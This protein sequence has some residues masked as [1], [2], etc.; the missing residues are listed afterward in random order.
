M[1]RVV[2]LTADQTRH[3]YFANSVNQFANVVGVFY[4][5]IKYNPAKAARGVSI[6]EASDVAKRHFAL[7]DKTE[8]SYFGHNA[9]FIPAGATQAQKISFKDLNSQALADKICSLQPDVILTFGVSVLKEP[10]ISVLP[11]RI[12][13][14]HIGLSPYYKGP[15]GPFF[16]LL[17]GEP[18]YCGV[19]IH[20]IDAGV[21]DGNIVHQGIPY[22]IEEDHPHT[23]G[24]KCMEIGIHLLAQTLKEIEC[25]ALQTVPQ[26]KEGAHEYRREDFHYGQ[27]EELYQKLDAGMLYDYCADRDARDAKVRWVR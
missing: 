10:V 13:N 8:L 24:C 20:Q 21:D 17:N 9:E 25:G 7:R 5:T 12:F 27:T 19:T 23:I 15:A 16:A 2:L 4:Q 26:W 18:E 14:M 22:I 3:R 11:G 1:L 6:E